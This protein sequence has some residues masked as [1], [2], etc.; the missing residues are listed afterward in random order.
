MRNFQFL[1]FVLCFATAAFSAFA[2][3]KPAPVTHQTLL[4]RYCAVCH[5]TQAKTAG[6]VLQGVD[7]ADTAHNAELLERV[8]RK[9]KTGQMPPPGM[10]RPDKPV[11][12]EFSKWLEGSLD[13]EA[14]AHPNPGRPAIHRL[15]RAEYGNA[16][17][18]V[19][20]LD[21]DAGALL[22]G[23]DTGYGFDN[24]GDVLSLSPTLLDRYLSMARRISR[25]ALGDPTLKPAEET[26][27]PRRDTAGQRPIPAR[28]EWVSDD[29]PFNS[30][31]GLSVRYYFPLDAEYVLRANFGTGAD[32][33]IE[34]RMPIKAGLREVGITFPRQSLLPDVLPTMGGRGGRGAA[35][36]ESAAVPVDLRLDGASLKR[37]TTPGTL[38][39]LPRLTNLTIS[40]PFNPTGSGDTA[41]RREILICR[42]ASPAEEE[43][44]AARI[45]THLTRQAYRRPVTDAD[46]RP[47]LAFYD[48]ARGK[49]SFEYGIQKAV[50]AVLI[51]PDFL[52][53]VESDAGAGK[54]GGNHRISGIELASRLSF[55]LWSSV[56]DDELLG[57][58]E[59]GKLA[60][61]QVLKQ[62]IQR[63]LDD[64]KSEALTSNFAGQ[65]LFIRNV[66]TA[67]PDPAIFPDFDE[68]LRA[69]MRRE[70]ELF[71][72]SIVRENRSAMDLLAANYTFLNDRLAKHYGISG[73]YG[74]QFRRVDLQN[75]AHRGGL[76]GQASILT[77]TSPPNR[78]SVVQRGKWV[79]DN[80][81][82]AP[83]APPPPVPSL[84]A[85]TKGHPNL[86]L[87]AALELHRSNPACA[88]CHKPM[89]P[90]GFALENYNGIGEWRTEDGGSEIDATGKLPDGT[91]FNG[92]AGLNKVLTTARRDEFAT[93]VVSKILTYA[94]GRGLEYYD[95][96][97]VRSILRETSAGDYRLRDLI[98]AVVMS[99]PFQMRRS[100]DR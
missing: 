24:I 5:S 66:E 70:S 83:P 78:T 1:S 96:P 26:F 15:N 21:I 71:F 59:K 91:E 23:D 19:F 97:V 100:P 16:I 77:V 89:D 2:Q 75:D 68:S 52:F 84:E 18:D 62:Q 7:P 67:R 58:A 43:G 32:K 41:S 37:A 13:A 85:T 4:Q 30:A 64:P 31:G 8:L 88:G 20:D 93:T 81:L 27:E 48:Q 34:V 44:C 9:I 3:T 10:P 33:A 38:G 11:L 61:P 55:F 99:T 76:L 36:G 60:D 51:S 69:S 6:V 47:L 87:R 12:D 73:I 17:R 29:L 90:L 54:A 57:L 53:R 72:D 94:L 28:L 92:P 25:L 95:Q 79:L 46:V 39:Q 42:P 35:G 49:G 82:G 50:E 80:I 86:S 65:W 98:T 56:P 22:P 45:L 40:G 63:M 14:A 74:S